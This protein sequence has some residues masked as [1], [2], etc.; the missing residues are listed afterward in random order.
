M[1]PSRSLVREELQ[2]EARGLRV[3]VAMPGVL[4]DRSVRIDKANGAASMEDHQRLRKINTI[5]VH[6]VATPVALGTR[7]S[8]EL[9]PI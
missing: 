5:M 8:M 9:L 7:R 3:V 2:A 1:V 6:E 4:E